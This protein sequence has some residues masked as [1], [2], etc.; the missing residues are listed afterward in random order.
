[1][2]ARVAHNMAH[3]TRPGHLLLHLEVEG[4]EA[5]ASA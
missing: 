3:N 2:E 1:M 4:K 5:V